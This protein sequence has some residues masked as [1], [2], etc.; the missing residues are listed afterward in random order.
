MEL[1]FDTVAE[2]AWQPIQ[3]TIETAD[4]T[5]KFLCQAAADVNNTVSPA[6][7]TLNEKVSAAWTAAQ[8]YFDII[9]EF[10]KSKLGMSMILLASAVAFV[11]ISQNIEDR[12]VSVAVLA[13]GLAAMGASG[14]LLVGSGFLPPPV[15]KFFA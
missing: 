15:A 10:V 7:Q 4:T 14:A 1:R 3:W 9:W 11:K 5:G 13:L 8:P 6:L 2:F 12:I